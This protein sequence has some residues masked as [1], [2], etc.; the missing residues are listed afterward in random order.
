MTTSTADKAELLRS[1]HIPGTPLIVTN[2]WDAVT[3]RIVA[4]APGV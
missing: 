3:A 4:G 1:L 2:V